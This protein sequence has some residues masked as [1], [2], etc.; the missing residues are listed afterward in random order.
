MLLGVLSDT[1][2]TLHPRL[3][4]VFREAGVE[5][6]LHAGDVGKAS[7]LAELQAL[8]PT[9]AV[10]GNIDTVG[11]VARLPEEVRF[12]EEE[13]EVYVTH[14]G[15]KPDHWLPRLP[16]PRPAVAICGHSHV[17][18]LQ[19]LGGV[20]FLNPGAAGTRPRF[21]RELTAAL[22]WLENGEAKVEIVTL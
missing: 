10:R 1:H 12:T 13:V 19:S 9:L 20:L 2:G 14:I 7:V 4:D 15:G 22:L 16:V 5:R 11:V 6:I 8:A 21:G 18:L 3:L 17:S